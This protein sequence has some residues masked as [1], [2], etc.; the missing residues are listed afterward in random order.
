MTMNAA[1]TG[2]YWR[3]YSLARDWFR[4]HGRSASQADEMRHTLHERALGRAKSSKDFT[5]A[6]LDKVLAA[7]RAVHDGGNLDAQ[8]AA[9]DQPAA[10][11]QALI[12]NVRHLA[13]DCVSREGT[14]RAY[15]DG[16]AVNLFRADSYQELDERQLQQLRG[17]LFKRLAQ[18]R[19]KAGKAEAAAAGGGPNPF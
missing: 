4:S 1:Q 9:E 6:D 11:V 7:F 15:L 2:L 17:V 12:S 16:L 18:L 5:N 3:E 13:S 8:L 14:E 19:K 10:R